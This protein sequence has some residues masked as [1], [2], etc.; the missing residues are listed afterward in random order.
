M[1][2]KEGSVG[3]GLN[4]EAHVPHVEEVRSRHN[5][6]VEL[7]IP[8]IDNI[9]MLIPHQHLLHNPLILHTLQPYHPRHPYKPHLQ[10]LKMLFQLFLHPEK[11]LHITIRINTN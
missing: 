1:L 9:L 11:L 4:P 7:K 10:T 2:L 8:L 5:E 3:N 6:A